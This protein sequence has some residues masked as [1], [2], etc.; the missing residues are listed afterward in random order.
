MAITA[1][2]VRRGIS[3][4]PELL[5]TSLQTSTFHIPQMGEMLLKT[6]AEPDKFADDVLKDKP[7]L[8]S[9]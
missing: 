3:P 7:Q 8:E 6:F 5:S 9:E 4:S 1:A 2:N